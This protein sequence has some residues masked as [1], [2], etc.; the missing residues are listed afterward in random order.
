MRRAVPESNMNAL[1]ALSRL[2]DA[3]NTVVG[4]CVTWLTLVVVVVSAGNAII[5]KTFQTSSNAWLELQWY[6]FG[7]I[8]LLAAGYTLLRNEHVRVDVLSSRLSRRKQIYI[9]IFGVI[10]FLMP[11][12]LLITYLSWPVFMDSF[13]TNEQSSNTGGLVRWP[14]KLLIPVG[15]GLLVLAGLSHLIKC[16][17]FLMGKCPDP[18]ARPTEMSAEEALALEIAEEARQREERALGAQ[19]AEGP[20]GSRDKNGQDGR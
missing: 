5:R 19:R 3:I 7:A 10:F 14:V 1:L 16:I 4:R 17:G 13:L 18:G 9:D 11:A 2:I 15:F 6:L 20:G 12:C 8:F